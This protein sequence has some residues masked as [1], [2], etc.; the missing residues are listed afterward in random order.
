MSSDKESLAKHSWGD[1]ELRAGRRI[2]Y[3]LM[4]TGSIGSQ[5]SQDPQRQDQ[6]WAMAAGFGMISDAPPSVSSLDKEVEKKQLQEEI[7]ALHEVEEWLKMSMTF[8]SNRSFHP[9]N[10][11]L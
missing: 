2:D 4:N 7:A 1:R 6:Y 8:H 5:L 9:T 3:K 10:H 11:I